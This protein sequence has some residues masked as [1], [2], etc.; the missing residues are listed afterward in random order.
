[1]TKGVQQ[2]AQR[3]LSPRL[4]HA[5]PPCGS[6]PKVGANVSRNLHIIFK[7][8]ELFHV[9]FMLNG[10]RN[11]SARISIALGV[12]PDE[13]PLCWGFILPE[14]L[15]LTGIRFRQRCYYRRPYHSVL[16]FL[17]GC[18]PLW[19]PRDSSVNFEPFSLIAVA[20]LHS[21]NLHER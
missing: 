18:N 1:M 2:H 10:D 20:P 6:E 8:P 4:P 12:L 11:I 19:A 21:K 15:V 13:M 14:N 16:G 17:Q 3:V 9:K 7:C 5:P